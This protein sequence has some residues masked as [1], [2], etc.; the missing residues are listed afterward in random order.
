[1]DQKADGLG[2][3]RAIRIRP[4][5]IRG[6][7]ITYFEQLNNQHCRLRTSD[8]EFRRDVDLVTSLKQQQKGRV[9]LPY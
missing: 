3:T 1:M 9:F 4:S 5:A 7:V 6:A 8:F 2:N